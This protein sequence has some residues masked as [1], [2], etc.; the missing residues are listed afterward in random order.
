MRSLRTLVPAVLTVV[1]VSATVGADPKLPVHRNGSVF[2]SATAQPPI[3]APVRQGVE[4]TQTQGPSLSGIWKLE[5]LAPECR[6]LAGSSGGAS[7]CPDGGGAKVVCGDNMSLDIDANS[8][9]LQRVVNRETL[10]M[11]FPPDGS[12]VRHDETLT[13][14]FPLDGSPIRHQLSPCRNMTWPT[15]PATAKY[16]HAE[17]E[18]AKQELEPGSN[19]MTTR[20]SRDGGV[21]VLRSFYKVAQLL[22]G[23]PPLLSIDQT[24]RLG[25]SPLDHLVVETDRTATEYTGRII[26][27]KSRSV[28]TRTKQPS[29]PPS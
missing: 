17:L 6:G 5:P 8:I 1:S 2:Q 24:Q 14:V 27:T 3:N 9:K 28:Y 29:W 11:V 10:T 15:D 20:A 23:N 12:P 13:M 21:I 26:K 16:L 4:L 25:L 7:G 19:D 18:A 22:D